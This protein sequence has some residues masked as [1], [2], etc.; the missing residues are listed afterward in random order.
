MFLTWN[1]KIVTSDV[2]DPDH[3]R[4][5]GGYITSE[6]VGEMLDAQ[7]RGLQIPANSSR[8]IVDIEPLSITGSM[9]DSTTFQSPSIC[10]GDELSNCV[11]VGSGAG[12]LDISADGLPVTLPPTWDLMV[13]GT[14]YSIYERVSTNIIRVIADEIPNLDTEQA[15]VIEQYE[16]SLIY[17][18]GV[19]TIAMAYVA[20]D[21][22]KLKNPVDVVGIVTCFLYTEYYNY[23]TM[24]SSSAVTVVTE[25][26][27]RSI[28]TVGGQSGVLLDSSVFGTLK[29][30]NNNSFSVSVSV[31]TG[32]AI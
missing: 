15:F 1:L 2:V 3:L 9:I 13:G 21:F 6:V 18:P 12:T 17:I 16:P 4:L 14:R 28:Q 27:A 20:P 24:L 8:T 19:G 22:V 10:D 25:T 23:I 31:I 32:K 30:V 29:I 5:N 7:H 11:V 26:G